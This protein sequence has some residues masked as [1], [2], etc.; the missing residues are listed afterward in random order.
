MG[1]LERVL[2][3]DVAR[4]GSGGDWRQVR[5]VAGEDDEIELQPVPED[6]KD[7]EPTPLAVTD[8]VY[9]ED[10]ETDAMELGIRFGKLRLTDRCG[11]R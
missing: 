1:S 8:A 9:E 7:L 4:S 2:E 6:E 10:A 3:H 5:K 11:V